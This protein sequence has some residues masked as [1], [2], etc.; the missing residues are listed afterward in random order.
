MHELFAQYPLV[1]L[2][3]DELYGEADQ[4][5]KDFERI[6]NGLLSTSQDPWIAYTLPER[7]N[8]KIIEL[9]FK[10]IS[11]E[12]LWGEVYDT[13]TWTSNSY[14]L[15][16]GKVRI[17]YSDKETVQLQQIRFDLVAERSV[18]LE[19]EQIVIN[20]RL[21]FVAYAF[22][23]MLPIMVLV[24]L[25]EQALFKLYELAAR[26]RGKGE[27]G[28]RAIVCFV[29]LLALTGDFFYNICAIELSGTLIIWMY[30]LAI[31]NI[32]LVLM[33]TNETMDG[34]EICKIIRV[35]LFLVLNVS[36]VEIMSG[37]QY[38]FGNISAFWWNILLLLFILLIFYFVIRNLKVAF[39]LLNISAVSL[40]VINHFFYQ[41]RGEPFELLDFMMAGT[42]LDVIS[43]YVFGI[44]AQLLYCLLGEGSLICALC[45]HKK[46]KP[47]ERRSYQA[48]GVLG[49]LLF[50]MWSSYSVPVSYWN[51][52]ESTR[53][54]GYLN[55]FVAYAKQD[56]QSRKPRGYSAEKAEGILA[57]YEAD[58]EGEKPNVI[59]IM[60]EAW[61]DLPT[62]YG[63][64]TD[65]DG[66]PFIHG[67]SDNTVKGH[68][69]V[70][71]FGGTTANTEYEF[72]TGN[73]MAFMNN[74]DV[75]YVQFVKR[76]RESF[77]W[78][79][80]AYGYQTIAFHPE[81]STNYNRNFVYPLFGFEQF[82]AYENDEKDNLAYNMTLRSYMS[83]YSDFLNIIDMY[84]KRDLE[85]PFYLFNVTMQN[86]GGYNM[87]Q[88]EVEVTVIPTDQE[89]QQ[90]QL[91]EYL[92]LVRATDDA[93]GMLVE[94]FQNVDEKTIILMFGDH[95]PGLDA[96][97]IKAY[98][99]E[100]YDADSSFDELEEKY[101]VPFV[102]WANYDIKEEEGIIT[103]P[104]YLRAIL[105]EAG[106]MPLSSYDKF[107]LQC[108]EAY[109]AMNYMAYMDAD[110]DFHEISEMSEE[111]GILWEYQVLQYAGM[112]DDVLELGE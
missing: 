14:D 86:H 12:G 37:T 90:V 52:I 111:D 10:G 29:T 71:V 59:V 85:R 41:F 36:I 100:L 31:V 7:A 56:M 72:L 92:S 103:S 57:S 69:L 25:L 98:A 68:M 97:L 75:P 74:G 104:N 54:Y 45:L 13:E 102:I 51:V 22:L 101:M 91:M 96:E 58:T 8:V 84:E 80:R 48:C 39:V 16:N 27:S 32:L 76:E 61:A 81:E 93:F 28:I 30:V 18:Y 109:P 66:M 20:P 60:N 95:Q 53:E 107:L 35:F 24:V 105:K 94:Y 82:V 87:D 40:G 6:D 83:D 110:G 64:E 34:K 63:F 9:H 2:E 33:F 78:D 1:V 47:L 77:T 42:A 26:R 106:K 11:Q 88:N 70:S 4:N 67:M 65:V 44:D 73:T 46:W 23:W 17:Y 112:F 55:S 89:L 21:G 15:K 49:L 43:N 99:P 5:L 38:N 62:T 50:C 108:N 19:I 3:Q 79:M